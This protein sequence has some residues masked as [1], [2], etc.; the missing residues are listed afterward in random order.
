ME[1]SNGEEQSAG[2]GNPGEQAAPPQGGSPG[3]GEGSAS[4]FARM[5]SQHDRRAR[6][7]PADDSSQGRKHD[8]QE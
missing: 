7:K 8:G 1:S 4:A 6:Q 2:P 3:S 5:K